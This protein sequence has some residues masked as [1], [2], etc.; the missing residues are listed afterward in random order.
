MSKPVSVT[1][2]IGKKFFYIEAL[3]NDTVLNGFDCGINEYND[4]LFKEAMP[5]QNEHIALTWLLREKS[6]KGIA[7]LLLLTLMLNIITE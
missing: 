7:A 4:Y 3:K 6:S 2:E 5:S 1:H